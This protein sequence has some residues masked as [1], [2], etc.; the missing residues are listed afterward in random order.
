MTAHAQKPDFVFRRNRQ[1]HLNR[2]GASVQSTTG[3]RGV[4]IS[5]SNAGYTMF[6]GSVKSTGYPLHSPVSPSLPVLCVILCHHF[7]TGVYTYFVTPQNRALRQITQ[8]KIRSKKFSYSETFIIYIFSRL[9]D[10]STSSCAQLTII[11][12]SSS[13][14]LCHSSLLPSIPFP[15]SVL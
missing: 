10:I 14:C 12:S 13:I 6:R 15:P 3:S 7:S 5:V 1:V 9:Y 4:R 11:L 8:H 2:P